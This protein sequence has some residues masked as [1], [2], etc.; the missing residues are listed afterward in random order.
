MF[1]QKDIDHGDVKRIIIV[2]SKYLTVTE[3]RAQ[4]INLKT[5]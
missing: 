3:I 4:R 5:T 2:I 1:R